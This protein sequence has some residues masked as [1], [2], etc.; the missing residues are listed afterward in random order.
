[1]I[2]IK[3]KISSD[4]TRMETLNIGGGGLGLRGLLDL[5]GLQDP[6]SG[7]FV[8]CCNK[9]FFQTPSVTRDDRRIMWLKTLR[10]V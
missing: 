7:I 1:M 5:L 9:I 8:V 3:R 10:H 4:R 2:S 6:E